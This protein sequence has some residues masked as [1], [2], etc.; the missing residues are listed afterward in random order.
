MPHSGRMATLVLVRHAKAAA[1]GRTDAERPLAERGRH[2]APAIGA[3]LAGYGV[4]PD[5]VV[6]SP[7][8]RAR[9][10]WDLASSALGS[11]LAPV[12]DARVYGNTVDDLLAVVRATPADVDTLVLVGH[13]PSIPE[14]AT[15]LDDSAGPADA[16]ETL[17]LKYP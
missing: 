16:R 12:A 10:T 5:R 4:V 7:A 9:Q 11:D 3:W 17:A 14:L 1:E 13:S 8:M 2:E 6:V 15:V